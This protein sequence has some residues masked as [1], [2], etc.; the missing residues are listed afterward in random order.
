MIY[1]LILILVGYIIAFEIESR[2]DKV[3]SSL[4]QTTEQNRSWHIDDWMYLAVISTMVVYGYN[5]ISIES[6]IL[7]PYI[8]S[9]RITYFNIRLNKRRNKPTFHLGDKGWDGIFINHKVLYFTTAFIM[10]AGSI[11]LSFWAI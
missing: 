7:I 6:A 11:Y 8:V 10:L 9:L 5:E 4:K 3:I 2:H 1:H